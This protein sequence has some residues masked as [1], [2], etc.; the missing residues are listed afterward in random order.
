MS[1]KSEHKDVMSAL[2]RVLESLCAGGWS[3]VKVARV[4]N[5]LEMRFLVRVEPQWRPEVY[6]Y[7]AQH[8]DVYIPVDG[9]PLN[10]SLEEA[11]R[12]GNLVVQHTEAAPLATPEDNPPVREPRRLSLDL[13][14][15][16]LG[17]TFQP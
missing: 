10:L 3:A 8:A 9:G 7:L 5:G 13:P 11:W 1:A 2:Y 14:A 16:A 15:G 6:A 17:D 4:P 12:V